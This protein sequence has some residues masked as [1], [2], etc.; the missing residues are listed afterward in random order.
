METLRRI[1]N[2]VERVCSDV[3]LEL[4]KIEDEHMGALF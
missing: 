2:D 4:V 1:V 3:E